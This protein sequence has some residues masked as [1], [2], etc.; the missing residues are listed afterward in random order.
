MYCSGT[1]FFDAASQYIQ[2]SLGGMDTVN[3]KMQFEHGSMQCSIQVENYH[4][5]NGIFNFLNHCLT[6]CLT[7]TLLFLQAPDF[8]TA[9]ET[10]TTDV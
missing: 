8:F 1:L 5:Y 2:V 10:H 3:A 7:A 6:C 4:M 9:T